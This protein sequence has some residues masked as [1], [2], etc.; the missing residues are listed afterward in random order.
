MKKII[1]TILIYIVI[2]QFKDFTLVLRASLIFGFLIYLFSIE[3]S[4]KGKIIAFSLMFITPIA[5][6]LIASIGSSVDLSV[7]PFL[8]WPG[9]VLLSAIT[10]F[11]FHK[12]K[13]KEPYKS[14]VLL[15]ILML[16]VIPLFRKFGEGTYACFAV[17]LYLA[18]GLY[19]LNKKQDKPLISMLFLFLPYIILH[20][21]DAILNDSFSG[22]LLFMPSFIISMIFLAIFIYIPFSRPSLK[23]FKPILPFL[24][25][26]CVLWPA[27]ENYAFWINSLENPIINST[28]QFDLI[29]S[30][31]KVIK[32]SDKKI[33]VFLFTSA[34]CGN[35]Y[36]EYPYYSELASKYSG[37]PSVSFNATFLSFR[38][39]DTLFYNDLIKSKY[40]FKWT[41]ANQSKK[42]YEDLK[43]EGVPSLLILTDDNQVLYN[44]YCRPRP[45][46]I[47]NSPE[48]IIESIKR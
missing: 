26:M 39:K 17:A 36:K 30:N 38:D 28:Y 1:A 14:A 41:I 6:V 46:I 22:F 15:S 48:R 5:A 37:D 23:S 35:C 21:S 16:I 34:Y 29:D 10:G 12:L 45:W 44:G 11:G 27:Q 43:M 40:S 25:L 8:F 47:F 7:K 31:R 9:I 24:L 19:I 3:L 42:V 33:N 20:I 13:L 2:L 4:K 32:S 18:A